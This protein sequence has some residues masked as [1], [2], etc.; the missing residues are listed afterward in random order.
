MGPSAGVLCA[1]RQLTMRRGGELDPREVVLSSFRDVLENPD[2]DVSDVERWFS[3][4]YRQSVDGKTMDYA[5]FVQHLEALNAAASSFKIDVQETV[6]E[7][8]RVCTRHDVHVFKKDGSRALAQVL[9]IFEVTN[10]K[11]VRCDELT[12]LMDGD[13]EDRDLGSRT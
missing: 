11:I 6:C 8:N 5:Q 13:I 9:A 1:P 7:G 3:P 12:R 2:A 10:G 4:D